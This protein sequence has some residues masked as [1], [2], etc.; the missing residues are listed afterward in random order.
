[1]SKVASITISTKS[2]QRSPSSDS[3]PTSPII[4]KVGVTGDIQHGANQITSSESDEDKNVGGRR[5]SSGSSPER[6]FV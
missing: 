1:M 6:R 3:S 4:Y 5:R 2:R